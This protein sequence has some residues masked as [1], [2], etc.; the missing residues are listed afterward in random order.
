MAKVTKSTKKVKRTKRNILKGMA[1]VHSSFNNTIVSIS[2]ENGNVVSWSSAGSLGFKG[3]RK[4]TPF[5]AGEA[6]TEAAKK[7]VEQGLKSVAVE[8]RG[9]RSGKRNCNKIYSSSRA[10]NCK[11]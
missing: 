11:Y 1:H 7:A 5:A 3:S 10:R 4:N 8:I 2:D 6:A 9:P